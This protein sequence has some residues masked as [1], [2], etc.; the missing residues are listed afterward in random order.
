MLLRLEIH[1]LELNYM[2]VLKKVAKYQSQIVMAYVGQP[3]CNDESEK[4]KTVFAACSKT[5]L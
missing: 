2:T 5:I 3:H 1:C 4:D